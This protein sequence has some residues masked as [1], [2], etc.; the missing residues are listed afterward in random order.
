MP[1]A[2]TPAPHGP[3]LAAWWWLAVVATAAARLLF[4]CADPSPAMPDPTLMDEGLWADAARGR[5]WFA[6]GYFADDLGNAYLVAPLYTWT[7]TAIYWLVGVGLW[8]TR[9]LS[10]LASIGTAALAGRIVGRRHGWSPAAWTTALLGLCPLLDQHGRFAL[11]E[12]SQSL[13]LLGSFA[14][15]FPLR[16]ATWKAV[17]AGAAM[18][19]A[20]LVKP[21][22]TT[23]GVLPFALAFALEWLAARRP[24]PTA[25]APRRWLAEGLSCTLGGAIVLGVLGLPVWGAHWDAFCATIEYE[26]GGANWHL[27]EHLLRLGIAG[28]REQYPGHH[29]LWALLRHAPLLTLAIWSVLL[30]RAEGTALPDWRSARPYWVWLAT[31]MIV[32][33]T[34]YDHVARRQVLFLPAMAILFGMALRPRT[35]APAVR[36]WPVAMRWLLLLLPLLL[37]LKPFA[38]NALAPAFAA[39][40]VPREQGAPGLLASWAVLV[41]A[42]VLPALLAIGGASPVPWLDALRRLRT[43]MLAG[44]GLFEFLHLAALSPHEYTVRMAQDRLGAAVAP[45][46]IVLGEHAATLLQR[47]PVRTV[48]RVLPGHSYSSPR[49]NP[50]VAERLHPRYV[51]DYAAPELRQFAD[52]TAADFE[53]VDEVG[54]LNEPSGKPRFELQLWR[55]R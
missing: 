44:A 19:A 46:A 24:S 52:V 50:D 48:R 22:S 2:Q 3:R 32:N 21:N 25:P 41:A 16:P 12:S 8:Q 43:P 23:F 15:L 6:E 34:S 28:S 10:A 51:L 36:P 20:V 9:L 47:I 39:V 31:A 27:G 35:V 13:C 5:L 17:L 11:L 26:S 7:L 1:A 30:R 45:G 49:P 14:L 54:L 42:I 37:L 55:R 4:L 38:A 40:G 53:V 29:R 33:E 18:G